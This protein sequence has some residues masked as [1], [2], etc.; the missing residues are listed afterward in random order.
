MFLIA[1]WVQQTVQNPDINLYP[2]ASTFEKKA[3]NPQLKVF[4]TDDDITDLIIKVI[5]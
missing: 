3:T 5:G 2:F 1:I 4:F